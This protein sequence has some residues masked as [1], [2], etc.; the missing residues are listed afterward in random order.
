MQ[1]E[2]IHPEFSQLPNFIHP[3]QGATVLYVT[4][5]QQGAAAQILNEG[6]GGRATAW[7]THRRRQVGQE[8]CLLRLSER[9]LLRGLEIDTHELISDCP[10]YLSAYAC[11]LP[12]DT[13][14]EQLLAH[15]DWDPLIKKMALQPNHQHFVDMFSDY[16]YTHIKLTLYP[17]GGITRFRAYGHA[18]PDGDER[19]PLINAADAS[20]GAQVIACSDEQQGS[21]LHLTTAAPEAWRTQRNRFVQAHEW[22]VVQL[23]TPTRVE[24]IQVD[25]R[26]LAGEAAAAYAVDGFYLPKGSSYTA[27]EWARL[28]GIPLLEQLP[29]HNN[30]LH[31]EGDLDEDLVTHVRLRLYPDGAVRQLFVWGTPDS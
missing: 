24:A 30:Q 20:A 8:F 5:E 17:D 18:R 31:H 2:I 1:T 14:A 11:C 27:E 9:A 26:G 4:N 6:R 29:M 7:R 10:P 13:T 16:P 19:C 22:A 23:S 21:A 3:Q 25:T 12:L 15:T 28:E